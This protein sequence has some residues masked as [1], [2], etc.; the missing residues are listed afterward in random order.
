MCTEAS[1]PVWPSGGFLR[2]EDESQRQQP[3]EAGRAGGCLQQVAVKAEARGAQGAQTRERLLGA[4]RGLMGQGPAPVGIPGH[5]RPQG[6]RL[7]LP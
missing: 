3:G 4:G 2:G 6:P 1:S 7:E 5:R